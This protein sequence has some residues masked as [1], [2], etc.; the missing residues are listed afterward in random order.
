[1]HKTSVATRI[2]LTIAGAL[3]AVT[4]FAQAADATI[5]AVAP[6]V[7]G[8]VA[9]PL[10]VVKPA[11]IDNP[12]NNWAAGWLDIKGGVKPYKVQIT[13]LPQGM[14]QKWRQFR[15]YTTSAGTF[16]PTATISDAT[17]ASITS[18][19]KI[20]VQLGTPIKIIGPTG[21]FEFGVG[22]ILHEMDIN[23][24][25]GSGKYTH[26]WQGLPPGITYHNGPAGSFAGYLAGTTTKAG[27]YK[28]TLT[29]TDSTGK[30]ESWTETWIVK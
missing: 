1:M 14:V 7:A 4:G 5:G 20:T 22:G 10:T 17:G 15:G 12:I 28:S 2:G 6:A 8:T 27:T 16:T 30:T 18:T 23:W 11:D 21:P 29:V 3:L 13:G 26:T 19:W 9:T 25:G 24:Y